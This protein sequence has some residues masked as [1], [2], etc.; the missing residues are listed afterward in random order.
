[1]ANKGR[2][3]YEPDSSKIIEAL[4]GDEY[5][6]LKKVLD[7]PAIASDLSASWLRVQQ[8]R[9]RLAKEHLDAALALQEM[10]VPGAMRPEK[11][12]VISRAYYAMFCAARAA[13]SYHES[14]DR[15]DHRNLPAW[16]RNAPFGPGPDRDRVVTALNKYRAARN[17]ADYSPFYPRPIGH[18]AAAAVKE[19]RAVLR[20]CTRWIGET[21][22]Q[23]TPPARKQSKRRGATT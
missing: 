5:E 1:M 4:G 20:I 17:E 3:K 9:L 22:R 15:N 7:R 21:R 18:D 12:S 16:V 14:A 2:K 10:G 8:A 19:A 11:R 23:R 13:L 6:L